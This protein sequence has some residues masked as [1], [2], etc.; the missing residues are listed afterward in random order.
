MNIFYLHNNP[1]TCAKYHTDKHVV[2]MILETA[3]ILCTAHWESGSNAPY[4]STHKNH[5]STK[6]ARTNKSNYKWLCELGQELCKEYTYR[7]DKTHK[8][9]QH[10]EWLS[11]NIPNIPNGKFTPPTLAMPIEYKSDNHVESYRNYYIKDKIHL[12]FWKKRNIPEFII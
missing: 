6:W 8:T 12:H 2:K 11:K 7:Y 1:K 5:P 9:Q 4:K 10:I 3:Q